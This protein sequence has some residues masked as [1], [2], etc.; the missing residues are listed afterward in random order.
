M[1][2]QQQIS[3]LL[4]DLE[5]DRVERTISTTN[6]DKFGEAICAFANDLPNNQLPGYLIIGADDKTGK[7]VGIDVTDALL[8]NIGSIRVEGNI[9]PQPSMTVEKVSMEGGDLIVV[10]VEPAHFPPV[11]Y[12]GK[13]CVRIGPRK[14][15][16][17]ENDEKKLLEKRAS[18]V[19]TF[20]AL[21]CLGTTLDD[22]DLSLFK[23]SYLSRAYPMDVIE[24]D[25][26]DIRLQMQSLGFYDMRHDCPTNAGILVFGK[27]VERRFPGAYIQYVY[28][29]GESRANDVKREYKF[30]GNLMNVLFQLDTFVK[31]TIANRRPVLV[32]ALREDMV[33]DYPSWAVRELL[34]N[35]ICH[36]DYESNGPVQFY[37]YDNRIEI[38]NPG[39]LYG[40]ATPQNFPWVN[41]YRNAVVAEAMKVLGFV[42]RFSR[43]VQRVQ[44]ELKQN[45]NGSAEFRLN[46]ETAF[47]VCVP[48]SE[49][50][51][52]SPNTHSVEH[53]ESWNE[54]LEHPVDE[55]FIDN[56]HNNNE[57]LEPQS[58]H[59]ESNNEHLEK[60]DSMHRVI[61]NVIVMNPQIQYK[62][63]S[64]RTG[65]KR[66]TLTRK[67]K[68][69]KECGYVTRV[70]G[71]RFGS[72]IVLKTL[73]Q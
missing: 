38:L 35:A 45:G 25:H 59:S 70:D 44:E 41:D 20:D 57:H 17:N 61:Y 46:L 3:A 13:T 68:E 50:S 64:E 36:R 15:Y 42:N 7:V 34:M 32:T 8:K 60:L 51:K 1:I 21:P 31:T 43:G 69:L 58:E 27:N 28:F 24:N 23:S 54:H 47:L 62:E 9:Q 39:A 66:A 4:N 56:T 73:P 5:S 72:W 22:M 65:I 26:R 53:L 16:A 48:V 19:L 29:G 40:K 30:S 2:N 6:M 11:K 10:E 63:I 12:K 14:G 18:H 71:K 33:S 49:T 67:I 55:R 52:L 37:Q